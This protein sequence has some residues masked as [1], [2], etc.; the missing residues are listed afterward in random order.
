MNPLLHGDSDD[1]DDFEDADRTT[2]QQVHPPMPSGVKMC[3]FVVLFVVAVIIGSTGHAAYEYAFL[4]SNVVSYEA[5]IS[6]ANIIGG[7]DNSLDVCTFPWAFMCGKFELSHYL[8]GSQIKTLSIYEGKAALVAFVAHGSGPS[9][10]LFDKC[11]EFARAPSGSECDALYP[12]NSSLTTLWHAGAQPS[13]I[14]ISRMANPYHSGTRTVVLWD[15]SD[16]SGVEVYPKEIWQHNDPCNLIELYTLIMCPRW[17]TDTEC[18]SP[19]FLVAGSITGLCDNW[20]PV[21][22]NGTRARDNAVVDARTACRLDAIQMF[23]PLSCFFR[24]AQYYPDVNLPYIAS[25]DD[26]SAGVLEWFERAK[27]GAVA[28]A[29]SFGPLV[30]ARVESISVHV[31]WSSQNLPVP[32]LQLENAVVGMPL[33]KIFAAFDEWQIDTTMRTASQVFPMWRM[34]AWDI[35]AYYMPSTNAIYIPDAMTTLIDPVVAS[36]VGTLMFIIAHEIGHSFDPSAI[37]SA[38]ASGH[39]LLTPSELQPYNDVKN[40]IQSSYATH[41]ITIGEDFADFIGMKVVT[42]YVNS[43]AFVGDDIKLEGWDISA[44]Q[45]VLMAFGRFWCASTDVNRSGSLDPHSLP[46][47]RLTAAVTR[48]SGKL[49]F[50]CAAPSCDGLFSVLR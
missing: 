20:T 36:T 34:N 13:R 14:G 28:V 40:C 25:R 41:D 35:N 30:K 24:T 23:S 9:K 50:S 22:A 38:N 48:F 43:P 18:A 33:V 27:I 15:T 49:G 39:P 44:K 19:Y 11:T 6:S 5:Y 31:S 3:G 42:N 26:K 12:V 45:Q 8:S 29:A 17:A 10:Q 37:A 1:E 16:S 32:P 2:S 47:D 46:R 7:I 4:P 21:R